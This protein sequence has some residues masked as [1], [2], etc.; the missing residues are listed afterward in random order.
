M[1]DGDEFSRKT[2]FYIY[3]ADNYDLLIDSRYVDAGV[4]QIHGLSKYGCPVFQVSSIWSVFH[5]NWILI[6]LILMVIGAYLLFYGR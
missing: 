5:D 6:G 1:L 4:I 2:E 3:C